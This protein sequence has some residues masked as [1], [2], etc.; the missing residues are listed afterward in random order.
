MLDY[1]APSP[2]HPAFGHLLPHGEG[3]S[4]ELERISIFFDVLSAFATWRLCVDVYYPLTLSSY[5]F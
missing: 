5:F 4:G 1:A 3:T 2:P